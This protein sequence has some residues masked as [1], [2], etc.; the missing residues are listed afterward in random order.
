MMRL[1]VFSVLLLS[2]SYPAFSQF[3]YEITEIMDQRDSLIAQNKYLK[4][5]NSSFFGTK[6]KRD[7]NNIIETLEEI[8][9][10]DTELVMAVRSQNIS[11]EYRLQDKNYIFENR[12]TEL[13]NKKAALQRKL[14]Q[15]NLDT[16]EI[17]NELEKLKETRKTN[18]GIILLLLLCN[19]LFAY[20]WYSNKKTP[21]KP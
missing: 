12:I 11:K 19:M 18:Q 17:K 2:L 13:E 6:S 16:E 3:R 21:V 4:E 14:A 8:I 20:L 10:K 9:K 15:S 5:R 7:L 1:S